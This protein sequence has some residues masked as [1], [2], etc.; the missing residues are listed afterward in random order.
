MLGFL[1][2][3]FIAQKAFLSRISERTVNRDANT[4]T[5]RPLTIACGDGIENALYLSN[6]YT[7]MKILTCILFSLVTFPSF[8]QRYPFYDDYIKATVLF[9]DSTLKTG[10][11]KWEGD[12]KQKLKFRESELAMPEKLAIEDVIAFYTNRDKHKF[13]SLSNFE[14]YADNYALLGKVSKIKHTFGEQLDSGRFNIYLVVIVG[15]NTISGGTQGYP[16]IVFQNTGDN[17]MGL[18]AYPFNM[19]MWDKKYEKAKE[20][21]YALFKDYPNIVEAIKNY[22]KEDDFYAIV[23]MVKAVN[24]Q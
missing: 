2:G 4:Y 14:G 22:K 5:R 19:R 15:V 1:L 17:T 9:K 24:R 10:M 20:N 23:E 13:I 12:P 16:N 7:L 3:G 11:V 8:S 21:L 18:V 6:N